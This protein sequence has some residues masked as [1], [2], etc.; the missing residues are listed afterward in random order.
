MNGVLSDDPS[1]WF[2]YQHFPAIVSQTGSQTELAVWD[3]G[4]SR[5][6]DTS[7][8]TCGGASNVP[9]YSRAA[10]YQIDDNAKVADMAWADA[11]GLYSLWGGSI[12]RLANG[13]V[14]FDANA[15]VAPPIANA[16]S[17]VQEVTHTSPAQVVWQ[18]VITPGTANAYRAYRFPSLYNGVTWQY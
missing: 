12:N 10:I 9:C 5:V 11:P 16:A 7:G 17:I 2:S 3:N 4:D 18:M 14:E 6:L 8:V 13:N 15:P 1:Q